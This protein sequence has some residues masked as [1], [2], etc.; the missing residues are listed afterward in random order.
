LMKFGCA[1]ADGVGRAGSFH[2]KTVA[3]HR[4]K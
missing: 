1:L 3:W 4:Y 2:S